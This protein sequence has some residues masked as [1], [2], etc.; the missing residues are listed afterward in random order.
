MAAP[1]PSNNPHRIDLPEYKKMVLSRDTFATPLFAGALAVFG[2]AM[3]PHKDE[4]GTE[5]P[6]WSAETLL[7]ELEDLLNCNV[8]QVSL[9]KIMAAIVITTTDRFY[10]SVEDFIAIAN[11]LRGSVFDPTV[12]DPATTEECAWAVAEATLLWPD[13]ELQF[14][15]GIVTYIQK[16]LEFEGYQ[17]VPKSL[18]AVVPPSALSI[19]PGVFDGDEIAVAGVYEH[20]QG[21][22]NDVDESVSDAFQR[23]DAQLKRL[24]IPAFMSE[25]YIADT[26]SQAKEKG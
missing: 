7:L 25:T 15:S 23:L 10:S 18:S 14:A 6:G 5:Q 16:V 9:D 20:H 1:A 13:A 24:K 26:L 22:A 3:L 19:D 17:Q 21:L 11:T 12:F 8:P 4:D 2:Q